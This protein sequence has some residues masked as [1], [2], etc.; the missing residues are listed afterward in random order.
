MKPSETNRTTLISLLVVHATSDLIMGQPNL[1]SLSHF[2]QPCSSYSGISGPGWHVQDYCVIQL[3]CIGGNSIGVAEVVAMIFITYI[4]Y[5][6]FTILI[7]CLNQLG[8]TVLFKDGSACCRLCC[9]CH[10]SGSV[11]CHRSVLLHQGTEDD[12]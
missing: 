11:H 10:H 5:K 7:L 12:D 9:V 8:T 2:V 1:R 3:E 4:D 6:F